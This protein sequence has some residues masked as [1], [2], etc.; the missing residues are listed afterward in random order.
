MFTFL[1][2]GFTILDQSFWILEFLHLSA[3][4]IGRMRL[5]R[6]FQFLIKN[7]SKSVKVHLGFIF[8]KKVRITPN[9]HDHLNHRRELKVDIL[10]LDYSSW[11][12]NP[13]LNRGGFDPM[14]SLVEHSFIK[15]YVGILF[16]KHYVGPHLSRSSS[17]NAN[18]NNDPPPPSSYLSRF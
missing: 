1:I 5:R 13:R 9:Y 8:L 6:N 16:I 15:H 14:C 7:L 17:C 12:N 3:V 11:I 4:D 10:Y 18:N 2:S